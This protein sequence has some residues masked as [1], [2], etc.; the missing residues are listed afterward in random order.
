[1]ATQEIF[2]K[3]RE[4]TLL[5]GTQAILYCFLCKLSL[6]K[7]LWRNGQNTPKMSFFWNYELGRLLL[8]P[9]AGWGCVFWNI[10]FYN[11][12]K[13]ISSSKYLLRGQK[14]MSSLELVYYAAQTW[15]HK[16]HNS[17]FTGFSKRVWNISCPRLLYAYESIFAFFSRIFFSEATGFWVSPTLLLTFWVFCPYISIEV[18][19][20][21]T[22][23]R[24][25][26][27][28]GDSK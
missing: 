23:L 22:R 24:A 21:G 20:L 12:K 2:H 14:N 17:K 4:I 5:F 11:L 7:D 28:Q 1:M 18:L 9:G 27:F 8:H 10:T 16:K 13:F 15:A 19:V 25:L 26:L 6:G 3:W